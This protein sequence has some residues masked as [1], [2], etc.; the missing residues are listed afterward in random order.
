MGLLDEFD[1]RLR[2]LGTAAREAGYDPRIVDGYRGPG[3]QAKAINS[4]AQRVLGRPASF[5]DF[6]RGI[7]GYAAPVG[8]SRHETGQA[9]DWGTGPALDWVRQNAARY[10]VKFPQGLAR[11]DPVHSELDRSAM[12]PFQDPRDRDNLQ[13]AAFE[14]N[15]PATRM[16]LGGPQPTPLAPQPSNGAPPMAEQNQGGFGGLL[17]AFANGMQSPLFMSGAAMY[18]AGAQGQNI[19]GGFLAGGQAAGHAARQQ[20]EQTKYQREAQQQQLR[21]KMW[22]DITSGQAPAWASSLPQGTLELARALGPDAGPQLVAKFLVKNDPLALEKHQSSIDLNKAH[23]EYYRGRT[24]AE[25]REQQRF[26]VDTTRG[27]I[28]DTITG[29]TKDIGGGK[30]DDPLAGYGLDEDG[31]YVAPGPKP[32]PAYGQGQG[33][34][35]QLPQQSAFPEPMRLGGPRDDI[36]AS[37]RLDEGRPQP[38]NVRVAQSSGY[39]PTSAMDQAKARMFG[40]AG[41]TSPDVAGVVTDAGRNRRVDVPATREAQGQRAYETATP[42]QQ[43]RFQKM[44]Q[45]QQFWSA[46]YNRAPRAGYYYGPDGRE[47]ALTDKNFKG[48]REGQAVAML[49][50]KK[51]DAAAETLKSAPLG[52]AQRAAQGY[53]NIGEIGQAY[54]DMKQAAMGIAYALS[55]KTVA[56]AE[57]KNFMDAYGPTPADSAARIETKVKRLKDFYQALIT[58]SRGGESYENAFARA[59]AGMGLKNPDGTPMGQPGAAAAGREPA[60]EDLSKLSTQDLLKRLGGGR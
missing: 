27:K 29:E 20:M 5:V 53:G 12:G 41:V 15:Q 3:D 23:A 39:V 46:A 26:K 21:D 43:Q 31:N 60:A 45:E 17:S 4:V 55:G 2:A 14:T 48:D 37:M 38:Q 49:N 33:E 50:L 35:W 44:R 42:E 59:A 18:N 7:P 13:A 52:M 8:G 36:D 25:R 10:G 24:N 30:P 1:T 19:G 57:M 54:V 58:A 16:A 6:A 51:I 47:L 22:G 34:T 40:P 28:I 9:A 11:T 56:V 32:A